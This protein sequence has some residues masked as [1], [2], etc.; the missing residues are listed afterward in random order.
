ME[1]GRYGRDFK[2]IADYPGGHFRTDPPTISFKVILKLFLNYISFGLVPS[3]IEVTIE[4]GKPILPPKLEDAVDAAGNIRDTV[5]E[6]FLRRV[7]EKV[8]WML[9]GKEINGHAFHPHTVRVPWLIDLITEATQ[10]EE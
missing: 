5:K 2:R 9:L 4:L 10:E 7:K 6:D 1:N 3:P 8:E